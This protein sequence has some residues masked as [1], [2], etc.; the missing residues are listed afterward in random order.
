MTENASHAQAPANDSTES[1][2]NAA[3]VQNFREKR[4]GEGMERTDVYVD[5]ATAAC[6]RAAA[7]S[8]IGA[9]RSKGNATPGLGVGVRCLAEI[10]ASVWPG[11]SLEIRRSG[12]WPDSIGDLLSTVVRLRSQL[13]EDAGLT[14]ED[15]E[16]LLQLALE[17]EVHLI[18][19][20]QSGNRHHPQISSNR[21]TLG[22]TDGAPGTE[23]PNNE[24]TTT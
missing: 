2:D 12:D 7:A 18:R 11:A 10:G 8:A 3:R 23:T 6:A 1:S 9:A 13:L 4:R 19:A 21:G 20:L 17:R 14:A 16:R 5:A 24:E 15:A 22:N